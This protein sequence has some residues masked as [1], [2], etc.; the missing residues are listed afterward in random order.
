M[1]AIKFNRGDVCVHTP[2][3][4]IDGADNSSVHIGSEACFGCP[5]CMGID[6]ENNMIKCLLYAYHE[7]L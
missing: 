5:C 6:L 2:T 7:K 1:K 4:P 3:F